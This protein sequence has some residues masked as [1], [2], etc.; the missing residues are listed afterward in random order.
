MKNGKRIRMGIASLI[1]DIRAKCHQALHQHL[2]TIILKQSR[3][4][5]G[6][7]VEFIKSLIGNFPFQ[8]QNRGLH[9]GQHFLFVM[10]FYTLNRFH[11]HFIG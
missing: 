8:T 2:L 11:L 5:L 6:L 7:K 3:E 1:T 10:L 4:F 9:I